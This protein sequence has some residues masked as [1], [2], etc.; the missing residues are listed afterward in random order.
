[1]KQSFLIVVI[2]LSLAPYAPSQT[3]KK[4]RESAKLRESFISATRDYIASLEKLRTSYLKSLTR[5]EEGLE[6]SRSLYSR[7]LISRGQLDVE[8]RAV[9][10]S[11]AK[12][13]EVDVRIA[14]A[15]KQLRNVLGGADPEWRGN[16]VQIP[17][18]QLERCSLTAEQSP[19]VRGLK[20]GQSYELRPRMAGSSAGMSSRDDDMTKPA[21]EVGR[22]SESIDNYSDRSERFK[23][24]DR[25]ELSYLDDSL[26]SIE[27]IY[28][29][30]VE[31][32]SSAHFA[33]A[34][35]NQ[36]KLPNQGWVDEYGKARL[37]CEGFLVEAT[38]L[39]HPRLKIEIPG[40]QSEIQRRRDTLEQKKRVEF[41]P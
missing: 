1:M 9:E 38:A 39:S 10:E 17:K 26:A 37:T 27:V 28:S 2:L 5:A 7:N 16:E 22:R 35:A 29:S 23:G 31:W 19:E 14:N 8:Y 34:V 11:K 25:V 41:K 24:V 13:A 3:S 4:S 36:L 20:L 32:Q 30:D 12:I 6:R 18:K 33:A 40:L 15:K 21:D